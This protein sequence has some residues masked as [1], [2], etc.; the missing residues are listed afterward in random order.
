MSQDDRQRLLITVDGMAQ[1]A[2]AGATL[3]TVL[4]TSAA[5]RTPGA[6]GR[7]RA[8]FCGMGLCFECWVTV[9]G[10]GAVRACLTPVTGGMRVVTGTQPP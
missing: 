4:L 9:E 3:A 8:M 10:Q 5:N 7:P 6:R 2:P 1:E